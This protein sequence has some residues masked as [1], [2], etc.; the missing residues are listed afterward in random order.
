[1][2]LWKERFAAHLDI[3]HA[4]VAAAR[5]VVIRGSIVH[6]VPILPQPFVPNKLKQSHAG[7][8]DV[9][10]GRPGLEVV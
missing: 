1:M 8:D 3:K 6:C 4:R 7:N 2:N 10:L 5:V 9:L